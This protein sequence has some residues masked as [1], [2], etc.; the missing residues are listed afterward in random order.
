M[1]MTKTEIIE[2]IEHIS[3]STI[4]E[5]IK[6]KALKILLEYEIDNEKSKKNNEFFKYMAEGFLS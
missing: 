1:T 2:K 4:D 5:K 3:E 6:L